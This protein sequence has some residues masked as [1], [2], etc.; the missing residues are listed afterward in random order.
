MTPLIKDDK[1]REDPVM[2]GLLFHRLKVCIEINILLD[3]S[4]EPKN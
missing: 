2:I 3:N 4:G 1:P